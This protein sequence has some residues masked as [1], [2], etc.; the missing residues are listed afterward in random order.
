MI[1][2]L[3]YMICATKRLLRKEEGLGTVEMVII[4]AVLVGIALI[5]RRYIFD[6]VGDITGSIFS[7]SEINEVKSNPVGAPAGK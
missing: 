5:F 1:Q 4:L 6:F 3:H 2:A 7:N